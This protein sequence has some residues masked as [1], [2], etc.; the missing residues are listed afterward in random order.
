MTSGA[1]A[2]KGGPWEFNLRDVFRW[3]DLL[4]QQVISTCNLDKRLLIIV[5]VSEVIAEFSCH[6]IFY[7]VN[8]PVYC[9]A[10]VSLKHRFYF[11]LMA[12]LTTDCHRHCR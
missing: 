1:F 2:R 12:I 7:N 9:H 4:S 10:N 3:C 5:L 6:N 8:F 11:L